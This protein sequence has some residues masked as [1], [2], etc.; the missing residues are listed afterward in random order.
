[1]MSSPLSY[2]L[3]I[4]LKNQ[5]KSFIRSPGKLIYLLLIIVLVGVTLLG[6]NSGDN[7]PGRVYHSLNE[8]SAIITAFYSLIFVLM[9]NK[10]FKDGASMFSMADVNMIFP[11][12]F[13]QQKVLFYGL[14]QQLGTSLLMGLFLLFQYSWLH[15]LYNISYGALLIILVGYALTVFMGQI[16]AMVIYTMTS[17]DE[18]KRST[19]KAIVYGAIICFV[20]YI[21]VRSL[22]DTGQLL[23]KAVE[24]ANTLVIRL[25]PVSGWLSWAIS[26][27]L[28]GNITGV[29]FGLGLCV[30]FLVFIVCLITFTKQDYYED[31][32]KGSE[33]LQAAITARKEGKVGDAAPRNVKLGKTGLNGGWGA[34]AI[35][36]KHKLENRRS[37]VFILDMMSL[38]FAA[39]TIVMSVFMRT[40][41]AG[42]T[43]LFITATSMQIF[44][45]ALGRFN[46]ELLKPY[47]YLIPEPPLKKMLYGLAEALPSAFIEAVIIFIPVSFILSLSPVDALFCIIARMS[48]AMLFTAGNIAVER[49]WGGSSSKSLVML[50][51]FALL[52]LMAVPGILLSI[53]AATS[54]LIIISKDVSILLALVV[55]NVPV[56]LLTMF[57]C[58][59]MLQY[60]ELNQR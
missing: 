35:Y 22:G 41:G 49:L 8:L 6:G 45:V 36:F 43:A 30:L 40:T 56:S 37:R 14:F 1:M 54:G 34:N 20:L 4:K 51:Y 60:A 23:T 48:F 2:L 16:T 7:N 5:L 33:Q 24:T 57:L 10:G 52:I 3:L 58:R 47:I 53:L 13:A 19:L 9:I 32:L 38:I 15:N 42:V 18:K 21:G 28:F 27:I 12:P 50:L 17:A 25:F 11:A 39:A 46:K 31:V 44:T 55:C 59:N 26:G 29:I